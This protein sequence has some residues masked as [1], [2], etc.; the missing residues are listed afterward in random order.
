M[1]IGCVRASNTFFADG[2][3]D[4]KIASQRKV[5]VENAMSFYLKLLKIKKTETFFNLLN[6]TNLFS[7]SDSCV[8]LHFLPQVYKMSLL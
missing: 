3:N 7:L 5:T 8:C 1:V 2:I 6:N 4:W